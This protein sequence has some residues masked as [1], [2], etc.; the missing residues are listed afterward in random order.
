MPGR[1]SRLT[2]V[3]A[4]RT[5]SAPRPRLRP[6]GLPPALEP[7]GI[8]TAT[9]PADAALYGADLLGPHRVHV[10]RDRIRDFTATYHA[11]L[12]RDVTLGYLDYAVGVTV[13]IQRL[14]QHQLIIVP[15]SGTSILTIGL[16]DIETSPVRAAVP[17]PNQPLRIRCDE[18]TAHLVVRIERDA[19]RLHLSRLL[20]RAVSTPPLFR[21][22]FDLTAATASRWNAAIQMLHAEL[23]EEDSLLNQ[24]A[25]IGQIEEF[26]MSSLLYSQDSDHRQF[27]TAPRARERST[28]AAAREHIDRHLAEALTVA[29]IAN[30][31]KTNVR[32]LQQHFKDDLGVTPTQYLRDARLERIRSDLADAAP[33][34][35]VTVS[36]VATRWGITHLGRFSVAYR[37]RFGESP[38]QTLA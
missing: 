37:E 1:L 35:G 26:I 22:I 30:A 2:T 6:R 34:S 23:F 10:D 20:G 4:T 24:G 27:L 19:L 7:H 12:L 3:N 31:A 17:P 36:D 13:E 11:V 5:A 33:G 15:A 8:Y 21:P 18:D 16:T 14:P 38:S 28:V 9:N 29:D 32:T 25:G